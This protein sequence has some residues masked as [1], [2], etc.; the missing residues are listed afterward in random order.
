MTLTT[1]PGPD[2]DLIATG[3]QRSGWIPYLAPFSRPIAICAI[4]FARC[5]QETSLTWFS[6]ANRQLLHAPM[7]LPTPTAIPTHSSGSI[8]LYTHILVS[9]Y[10]AG[11]W[12]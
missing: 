10:E 9:S 5:R 11:G 7:S 6:T 2:Q 8:N 1:L 12:P 3:N 4:T